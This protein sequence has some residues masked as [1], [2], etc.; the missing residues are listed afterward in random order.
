M[1]VNEITQKDINN[2]R[3]LANMIYPILIPEEE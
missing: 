2:A 1:E 3:K